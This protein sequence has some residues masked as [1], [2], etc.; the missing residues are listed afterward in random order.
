MGSLPSRLTAIV[1][2]V[3]RVLEQRAVLGRVGCD[4]PLLPEEEHVIGVGHPG[5]EPAVRRV[6]MMMG[7]QWAMGCS[8]SGS[9]TGS[10][11]GGGGCRK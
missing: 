4:A 6:I 9:G 1:V 11:T 3:S 5:G 8:A 10:V 7:V 2:Q